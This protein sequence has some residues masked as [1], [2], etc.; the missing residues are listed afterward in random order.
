[1]PWEMRCFHLGLKLRG[2]YYLP[3]R[4]PGG[5]ITPFAPPPEYASDWDHFRYHHFGSHSIQKLNETKISEM[6]QISN[7]AIFQFAPYFP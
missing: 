4:A 3:L 2:G 5:G 7:L 6:M 1:M